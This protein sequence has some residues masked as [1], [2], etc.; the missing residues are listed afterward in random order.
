[1]KTTFIYFSIIL[2]LLFFVSCKKDKKEEVND[3]TMYTNI[4]RSIIGCISDI[5]N[6]NIAGKPSGNQNMTVSGPLGGNVTI[7][8]SNTVDDNKT[9]SLDF[10]YS[11]ESVKYVFVSQYYTTTL[12]LTGTI[13]E[14]G[15]FN[16]NDKYLSINYKSDNLKVVGSIYYTKN[17]KINRDINFSG[18]ININRNYY[19]TNSIIFGETV[20]Y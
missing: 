16:N 3:D 9:N 13:N 18:N 20:S 14:T 7:T 15:S 12:T 19:Q 4:S 11:L 5:Y 1:M 8:G 2:S 6:Q 10:L 17:E